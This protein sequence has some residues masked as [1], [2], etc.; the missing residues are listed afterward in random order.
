MET[1]SVKCICA[2]NKHCHTRF[3]L[4]DVRHTP[5]GKVNYTV[6]YA[7]PGQIRGCFVT[8][9]LMLSTLECFYFNSTCFPVVMKHIRNAYEQ[10]ALNPSWTDVHPLVYDETSSRFPPNT[11]VSSILEA[12][13]IER[14]ETSFWYE[15]YYETCAPKYCT[16]SIT[17]RAKSVAEVLRTFVCMIS[18][19]TLALRLLTPQ[20]V[21]FVYFLSYDR[22]KN[23]RQRQHAEGKNCSNV[24]EGSYQQNVINE[25]AQEYI[26]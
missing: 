18:G 15:H 13:L 1:N 16:Y 10:N 5:S 26:T 19:V 2:T 23:R 8:D 7:I 6:A 12:L 3:A 21:K 20:L 14:W 11:S 17:I 25:C 24:F 4:Y 22:V 9:S